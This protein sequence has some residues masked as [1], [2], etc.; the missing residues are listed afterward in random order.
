M[1]ARKRQ[2][3]ILERIRRDGAAR[4]TD[5]VAELGVSDMTVRRDLSALADRGL[6]QKVHGGAISPA[7]ASTDE[8][9]FAVKLALQRAEKLALA[10]EVARVV[11]PGSSIAISAGTTTHA[12]AG[13]L[14]DVPDLTVVTNSLQVADVFHGVPR[15]D[16]TVIVTGGERTP[17]DALVGPVSVAALRTLHVDLLILGVHGFDIRHGLTTPNLVEAETDRALCAAAREIV[18][19]ADHTKMGVVGL[20]S[21]ARLDEVD[22]LVTDEGLDAVEQHQLRQRVGRL[23]IAAVPH[24]LDAEAVRSP[25]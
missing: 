24:A 22:I 11:R 4:V 14:L 8:P 13:A 9:G 10:Q 2:E 18:V 16:R 7:E 25:G 19:A 5:L 15:S 3:A 6:V 17:S 1:L 12:V 20:A 23:V 21:I